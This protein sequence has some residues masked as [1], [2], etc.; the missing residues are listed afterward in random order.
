MSII[1][2]AHNLTAIMEDEE[3]AFQPPPQKLMSPLE[4]PAQGGQSQKSPVSSNMRRSVEMETFH[5]QPYSGRAQ[6]V[7]KSR[8]QKE[9]QKVDDVNQNLDNYLFEIEDRVSSTMHHMRIYLDR[10]YD[11]MTTMLVSANQKLVDY[12]HKLIHLQQKIENDKTNQFYLQQMQRY[13]RPES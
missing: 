3:L 11:L 7:D 10:R 2:S 4:I 5:L 9:F 12:H 8:F 1:G 6:K 13:L